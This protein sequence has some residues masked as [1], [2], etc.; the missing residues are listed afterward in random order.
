VGVEADAIAAAATRLLSEPDLYAR[1]A[2]P[3]RVF[4]DGRA[5]ER[6]ASVLLREAS[7]GTGGPRLARR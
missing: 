5:A 7:G 3:S 2:V 6:I 1:R 4:G